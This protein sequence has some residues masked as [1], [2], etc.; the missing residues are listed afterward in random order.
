MT[1]HLRWW[2]ISAGSTEDLSSGFWA[3]AAP[4]AKKLAIIFLPNWLIAA[5]FLW[6]E[7]H[8]DTNTKHNNMNSQNR[9]LA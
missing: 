9:T 5:A 1:R 8:G 7:P 4:S 6:G 3:K 2:G